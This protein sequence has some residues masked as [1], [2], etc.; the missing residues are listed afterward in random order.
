[1]QNF[2][3]KGKISK[4][5]GPPDANGAKT[6]ARVIPGMFEEIVTAPLVIPWWLRGQMGNLK[7]GSEVIF[8]V[9]GD[10]SGFIISRAD[11]DGFGIIP[12]D[13]KIGGKLEVKDLMTGQVPSYNAHVHGGVTGGEGKTEKPV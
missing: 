12:G 7:P 6:K 3:Q 5:E 8:V 9:F 1:M 4:I 11:G 2:I 13:I 10:Q